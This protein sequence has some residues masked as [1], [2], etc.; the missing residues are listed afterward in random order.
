M[1]A[2]NCNRFAAD[3]SRLATNK[4]MGFAELDKLTE[5]DLTKEN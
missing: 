1:L 4:L 2:S 5:A 3:N